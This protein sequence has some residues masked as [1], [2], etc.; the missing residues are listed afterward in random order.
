[1][2]TSSVLEE[3][4]REDSDRVL[5]SLVGWLGDSPA[6][7]R[8]IGPSAGR[9]KSTRRSGRAFQIVTIDALAPSQSTKPLVYAT[10]SSR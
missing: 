3:A 6:C 2:K 10:Q 5:T 1:M 8:V 9:C 7:E 4:V